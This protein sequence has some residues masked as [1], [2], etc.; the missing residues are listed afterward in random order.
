M[1]NIFKLPV[2][3]S[4]VSSKAI[5]DEL[6][7]TYGFPATSKVLFIHQGIN[8]T[9]LIS[10]SE[11]KYI[12]RIYRANWKSVANITAE[13]DL[14]LL[15]NQNHI[16]VSYPLPDKTGGCIQR[17][18][19]PEGIR[20][21]VVFSHALGEALSSLN[22]NDASIFGQ[23]MGRLHNITEGLKVE[24][25]S[26]KYTPAEILGNTKKSLQ[27]LDGVT[28]EIYERA[29][30][31]LYK[32]ENKLTRELLKNIRTGICHGDP[33]HENI[34]LETSS[35]KITL[36]DFDFCGYGLLPY[37]LGCFSRYERNSTVN[38]LNFLNG[39]EKVRS[40]NEIEKACLP[41]FEVLM[42]I[43]HL[44]TKSLNADGVKNSK[45]LNSDIRNTIIEIDAQLSK[46]MNQA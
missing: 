9:Y 6:I 14:L 35:G 38:R 44:G 36:F 30:N 3:Y 25:L 7:P 18:D 42:R 1:G 41:Y 37:D 13:L 46:I 26:E 40:L 12:L 10:T 43:F 32:L 4:L 8:D 33:H 27:S 45:W 15:L 28:E 20:F 17:I 23:Y 24:G 21:A 34:F 22:S 29:H 19:C 5:E 16:S 39:Y 11:R 2:T 31:I